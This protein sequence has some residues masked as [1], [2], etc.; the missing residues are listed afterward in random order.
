MLSISL[1]IETTDVLGVLVM[2]ETAT[3]F[4]HDCFCFFCD[5]SDGK[6]ACRLFDYKANRCAGGHRNST[7]ILL[8]LWLRRP[9]A[10]LRAGLVCR[11]F[12]LSLA[13]QSLCSGWGNRQERQAFLRDPGR[14]SW[15]LK[16]LVG[17]EHSLTNAIR[18]RKLMSSFRVAEK[19]KSNICKF[20]ACVCLTSLHSRAR[21]FIGLIGCSNLVNSLENDR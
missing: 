5:R 11:E 6:H 7:R 14:S 20:H 2:T 1:I 17:A 10:C 19:R 15:A 21:I 12:H 8:S 4:K 13:S 16:K 18:R 3:A 9:Q